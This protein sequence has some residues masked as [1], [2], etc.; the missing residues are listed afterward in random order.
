[1]IL[2]P[3]LALPPI[4]HGKITMTGTSQAVLDG[5]LEFMP[6]TQMA[7]WRGQPAMSVPLHQISHGLPIGVPTSF[8][9]VLDRL[10]EAAWGLPSS[11]NVN[12]SAE[13]CFTARS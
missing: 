6:C 12:E 13:V 2:T 11:V 5:I 4:E 10:L 8:R 3:T 7:N 1:V 9:Y